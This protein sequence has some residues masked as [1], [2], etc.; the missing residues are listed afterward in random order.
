MAAVRYRQGESIARHGRYSEALIFSESAP[1]S[2]SEQAA[3]SSSHGPEAAVSPRSDLLAAIGWM[4][5]GGAILT[6]SL[7]MDRL[8]DQDINPYTIPGLL[9]G[10]LGIAMIILGAL[11]A[12]RSW[13]APPMRPAKTIDP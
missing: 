12:L 8:E 10:L 6:G 3:S 1:M 11:L 5:L 2:L 9:P 7:M 4:V 13:R